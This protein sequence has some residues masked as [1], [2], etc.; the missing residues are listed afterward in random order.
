MCP[1]VLLSPCR[2]TLLA[3]HYVAPPA[4]LGSLFLELEGQGRRGGRFRW[5][6]AIKWS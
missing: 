5:A 2:M 4:A 3:I 1:C 6:S